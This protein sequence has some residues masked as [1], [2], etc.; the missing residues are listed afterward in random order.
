MP[1]LD[2]YLKLPSADQNI[3][4]QFLSRVEA[5]MDYRTYVEN[6]YVDLHLS[7]ADFKSQNNEQF[8]KFDPEKLN[9]PRLSPALY[10]EVWTRWLSRGH[11]N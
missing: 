7:G 11:G 4:D 2:A 5:A 3:A 1:T 9:V 8:K 10:R 6:V